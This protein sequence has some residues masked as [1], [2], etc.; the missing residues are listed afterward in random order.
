MALTTGV[1]HRKP[2]EP[3]PVAVSLD[4]A[5]QVNQALSRFNE[6]VKAG[7]WDDAQGLLS[8]EGRKRL[9]DEKKTLRESL[10]GKRQDDKVLEALPTASGSHTTSTARVDCVYLFADNKQLIVSLTVIKE[11]E[12][13][14]IDSWS[15]AP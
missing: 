9:S 15:S 1:S 10:L 3:L 4:D 7:K 5:K 6:F 11:N 14:V 13:L 2:P 8:A 12:R